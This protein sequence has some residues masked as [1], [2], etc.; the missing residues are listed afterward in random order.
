[1]GLLRSLCLSFSVNFVVKIEWTIF[2]TE[3]CTEGREGWL[4]LNNLGVVPMKNRDP[5]YAFQVL[6]LVEG[7]WAFHSYP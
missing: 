4:D 6:A 5:G 2:T 1:M 7:L 3:G